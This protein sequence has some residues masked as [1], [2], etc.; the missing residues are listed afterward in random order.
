MIFFLFTLY[1]IPIVLTGVRS[2]LRS[3]RK[4]EVGVVSKGA[5]EL[6]FVSVLVPVKNEEKVVARLLDALL[7]LDYPANKREIIVVNDA[8][9]DRSRE[10]C[11]RYSSEHPEIR[12]LDRAVSSTKAAALNFGLRSARGEVVCTFDGDSVPECDA[13]LKAAGYFGDASVAGVQGRICSINAGQNMLTR[14]LSYEGAVQYELYVRGK[15]AL[16]LYV[17]LA[18]TCQFIRKSVLEEVGGWNEKCLAED[19]ELSVRLVEKNYGIRYASDVRTWEESPFSVGGLVAQRARWFR[20]FIEIGAR[21]G[22]LIRRPSFRRFDTE[23]TLFGTF[24]LMLCVVNY[25]VPLWGFAVPQTFWTVPIAQFT[26]VFTLTLL[27]VVG[28]ALA[29]ASRPV[30]LRNVLWLPFIFVYWSFQSFIAVYA[31]L[32]VVFRR[33]KQWQKTEHTGLPAQSRRV[34]PTV[35]F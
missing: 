28:V 22:K 27:A 15:D 24:V 32:L 29:T 35:C 25:I 13:L 14:F 19:T 5:G 3:R 9:N 23:V 12:V 8:S 18:G 30:R 1:N 21:F 26:S 10:I 20:G 33:P 2:L 6:P 17:G 11:T 31:L 16:N 4:S 7:R 34:V